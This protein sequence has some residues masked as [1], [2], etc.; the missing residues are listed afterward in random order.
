[1][2]NRNN[3]NPQGY[4]YG[5]APENK[6]PFWDEQWSD[7]DISATAEVDDT[8]GSPNVEVTKS[9]NP[10]GTVVNF[11]FSFSGLKGPKGD[12]GLQ[13]ETGETGPQGPQGIQGETGPQGPRGIQGATGET[14]PQGPKGDKG[15]T[16]ET[17]PQGPQGIQGETG[18]QGIQGET[19]PQGIQG[20]T[21]PQGPQGIQG[22][23]GPQGPQGIQGATGPQGPQ[24]PQGIPGTTV[25][26]VNTATISTME[27]FATFLWNNDS[28]DYPR[29][30]AYIPK[31]S[32]LN[33]TMKKDTIAGYKIV[34][35]ASGITR[36][37]FSFSSYDFTLQNITKIEIFGKNARIRADRL[38]VTD[39]NTG[40]IT[41]LGIDI[42]MEVNSLGTSAIMHNNAGV[43][44]F[45]ACYPHGYHDNELAMYVFDT[46]QGAARIRS[47]SMSTGYIISFLCFSKNSV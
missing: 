9:F 40:N 28:S 2:S 6:N 43:N 4:N 47:F 11:D 42:E 14:G 39:P 19:G 1:M 30:V 36:T 29:K 41:Y 7:L 5:M 12:R 32:S 8:T 33:I 44:P 10:S 17:G 20:E 34:F 27:G 23:T 38:Y 46:A 3:I 26:N 13:G 22:E 25:L 45:G 21:G 31:G 37:S 15:D 16:G 24:G 18:P 35:S